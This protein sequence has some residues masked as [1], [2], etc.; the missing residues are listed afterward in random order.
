LA[1]EAVA[2]GRGGHER[3]AAVVRDAGGEGVGAGLFGAEPGYPGVRK[4]DQIVKSL[5]HQR[6]L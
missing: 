1:A 5:V 4:Q 3:R 6:H 2:R